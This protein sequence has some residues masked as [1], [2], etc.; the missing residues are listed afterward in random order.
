MTLVKDSLQ[1]RQA[2]LL[3]RH[4]RPFLPRSQWILSIDVD[5]CGVDRP[6][7]ALALLLVRDCLLRSPCR[8]VYSRETTSGAHNPSGT[9]WNSLS[10]IRRMSPSVVL[11]H[12][13]WCSARFSA[14]M[15]LTASAADLNPSSPHS[16][17]AAFSSS[18]CTR[19]SSLCALVL[20]GKCSPPQVQYT[21]H[22]L[23]L[24][25]LSEPKTGARSPTASGCA[26]A[27][28]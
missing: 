10:S 26:G 19:L 14:A 25:L 4:L 7:R 27:S 20:A 22:Q 28:P 15:S 17:F 16:A 3:D 9:L 12:L 13:P 6:P 5:E 11:V 2:W 18:V 8:Y 23:A 24:R 1:H 21:R